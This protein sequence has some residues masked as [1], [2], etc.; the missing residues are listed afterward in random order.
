MDTSSFGESFFVISYQ[1]FISLCPPTGGN[2]KVTL[3]LP[4]QAISMRYLA[5]LSGLLCG[6]MYY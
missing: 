1:R 4:T 5:G 3:G 2:Q 6:F